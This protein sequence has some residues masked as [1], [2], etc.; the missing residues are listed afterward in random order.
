MTTPSIKDWLDPT[1]SLTAEIERLRA[2]L[3]DIANGRL[4]ITDDM[5]VSKETM[6]TAIAEYSQRRAREALKD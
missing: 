5:L 3:D 6:Q 4:S 1:A 2:A